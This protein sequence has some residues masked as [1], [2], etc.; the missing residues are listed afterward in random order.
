[1]QYKFMD[2]SK[3]VLPP[4]TGQ[5]REHSI[6][7][8]YRKTVLFTKATV[9]YAEKTQTKTDSVGKS[10]ICWMSEHRYIQVS[11]GATERKVTNLRGNPIKSA[12]TIYSSALILSFYTC[13]SHVYISNPTFDIL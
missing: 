6:L 12:R 1:M 4:S 2:V 5:A 3:E 9:R 13:G 11:L 10:R 8:S 7:Y